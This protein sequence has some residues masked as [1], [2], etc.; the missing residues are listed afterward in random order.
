MQM[1]C[2]TWRVKG[3]VPQFCLFIYRLNQVC[4]VI[5]GTM[6]A[7]I[8]RPW[9]QTSRSKFSSLGD[10]Y[11]QTPPTKMSNTTLLSKICSLVNGK[12]WWYYL[13]PLFVN[14]QT[15]RFLWFLSSDICT[16][17]TD[18]KG[19]FNTRRMHFRKGKEEPRHKN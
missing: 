9:R 13:K 6:C 5:R 8:Q 17:V 19:S 12:K 7:V 11:L 14:T 3:I 10:L 4:P 1:Q 2:G 18:F 16:C 15:L